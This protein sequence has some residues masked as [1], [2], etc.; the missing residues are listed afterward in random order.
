MRGFIWSIK[1]TTEPRICL[2]LLSLITRRTFKINLLARNLSHSSTLIYTDQQQQHQQRFVTMLENANKS[3]CLVLSAVENFFHVVGLLFWRRNRRP[4]DDLVNYRIANYRTPCIVSCET[5]R[6]KWS[7]E[8]TIDGSA[9]RE[10]SESVI[11]R[12]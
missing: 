8:E 3:H 12:N 4:F 1:D 2:K 6:A 10:S 7:R 5:I 9:C 11:R